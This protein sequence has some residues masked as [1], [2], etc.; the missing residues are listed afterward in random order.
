VKLQMNVNNASTN[1]TKLESIEAEI[2]RLVR[3][4]EALD[5]MREDAQYAHKFRK[6][7]VNE[8]ND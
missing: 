8:Q 1:N 7:I 3:E 6:L 5:Q 4:K 2:K